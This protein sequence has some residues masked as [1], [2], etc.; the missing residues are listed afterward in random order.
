MRLLRAVQRRV[1]AVQVLAAASGAF[2]FASVG[3]R[4]LRWLTVP[5]SVRVIVAL[6]VALVAAWVVLRRGRG[7]RTLAAA[8]IGVER[9][10]P[11]CRNLVITAE[12]IQRHPDR[13]SGRIA[14]QVYA[15]AAS[16]VRDLTPADVVPALRVTSICAG[17]LLAAFAILLVPVQRNNQKVA[18]RPAGAP[19][20]Q[21]P[22]NPAMVIV[23]IRPPAYTGSDRTTVHN[24][25]RLDVL[26]GSRLTLGV[27]PGE[28]HRVRY[29]DTVLGEI[30]GDRTVDLVA[31]DNGYFAVEDAHGGRRLIAVA[32]SPDRLP[33]VRIDQPAR[34]L[35]LPDSSRT[36]P[37]R[38]S[39]SDDLGLQ[40]LE[41][42]YTK[43]SG[44]GEQFEFVEGTF[45]V[46]VDRS[47]TREW[48]G[49]ST[50]TLG[51]LGLEPGDSLVYR[52][53]AKDARPGSEGLAA[54]DT[55]FIEIAGP[56]QVALAG[57]DMPPDQERYALSQQMIVL[58]I[59]R[60]RGRER[61]LAPE[62]VRAEAADIA[63]EQR[64]VRANFVF[65]LGG[66]VEDEEVEAEQATEISEGRLQNTARR[67]VNAAIHEMTRAEQGLVAADTGGALPPARAAVAALQ[68]AFGKS[69][70][71]LRALPGTGRLDPARR[72]SGALTTAAS[73][74]RDR[75]GAP[76]REGA[77][78]R[79]L[80]REVAAIKATSPIDTRRVEQLAERALATN[81]VAPAWQ[82][83]SRRLLALRT[84][85]G[86]D[87]RREQLD[88]V[89][90][91][92]QAEAERG[93]LPR[94]S[95]SDAGTPL[96][97]AWERQR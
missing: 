10:L 23:T 20:H 35:V 63:A 75:A 80:L 25:E 11:A 7:Q 73:W 1:T 13:A 2:V 24:P 28:P 88:A 17:M 68:R 85:D 97:R 60:L 54:S 47:S 48:R 62:R 92:L 6:A 78:A 66:H 41:L 9:T 77:A 32:V 31:R 84:A 49:G 74:Q 19:D 18:T 36:I 57:V 34:D 93:L 51:T 46:N 87:S 58:K 22:V 96:Q 45:P 43:V 12:E 61:T 90:L 14:A 21:S 69:R 89:V 83:I 26:Q 5:I 29:G 72:L 50:L 16:A 82:D 94:T 59:E 39:A 37:V 27:S 53:V 56:G 33:V 65:L 4:L 55:Y 86:H 3:Y 64:A 15:D 79:E 44:T 91:K 30:S 42:R 40:V 70:Y 8:A 67:D 81:A 71:L 76:A 52:A 95:L 38:L